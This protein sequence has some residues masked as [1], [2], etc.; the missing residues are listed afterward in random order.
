MARPGESEFR[1]ETSTV[2]ARCCALFGAPFKRCDAR[3]Q[4]QTRLLHD[5]HLLPRH[6]AVM[7]VVGVRRLDG[8]HGSGRRHGGLQAL[9][10]MPEQA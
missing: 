5:V 6:L 10:G 9:L 1:Q 3:P 4:L 2:Q 7:P 8:E